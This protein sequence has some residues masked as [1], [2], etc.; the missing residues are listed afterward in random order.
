[1]PDTTTPLRPLLRRAG[2][3][4]TYL[5]P[6][7]WYR[8]LVTGEESGGALF[9]MEALVPPG[10]GPPPHVHTRE[11]E[12]FLVLEGA[13]TFRLGDE[14]VEGRAG[15]V[16]HVPK[17]VVHNFHNGGDAPARLVLTFTPAGIEGFFEE[18][19]ERVLGVDDVAPDNVA[20]VAARHAE[21]APRYGLVFVD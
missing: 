9:V 14:V 6:G 18:A 2:E 13:C 10:G 5:G 16:V 21:A 19:L 4:A 1:M 3:G 8:F 12:T 7:D 15:D 20:E 11:D 17:G